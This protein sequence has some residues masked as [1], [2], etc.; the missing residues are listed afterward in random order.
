MIGMY[1]TVIGHMKNTDI[2]FDIPTEYSLVIKNGY[3]DLILKT[4]FDPKPKIKMVYT[5]TPWRGLDV[6]LAAQ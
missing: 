6:L 3:D 1:L 4:N 2:I 5:S